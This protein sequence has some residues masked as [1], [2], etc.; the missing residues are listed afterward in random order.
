MFFSG[1]IYKAQITAIKGIFNLKVVSKYEK[2]LGLPPMIG[3]KKTSF[4]TMLNS[5]CSIKS[6]IGNIRC[7]PVV[8]EKF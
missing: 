3:R 7:F 4:L 8:V 5:R 2:Y 6:Q 1:K